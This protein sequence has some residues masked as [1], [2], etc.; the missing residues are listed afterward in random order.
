VGELISTEV[1]KLS[2][3]K[4]NVN[5]EVQYKITDEDKTSLVER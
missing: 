4:F 1:P 2:D 3:L 5:G